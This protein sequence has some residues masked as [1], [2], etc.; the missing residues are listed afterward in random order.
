MIEKIKILIQEIEGMLCLGH[1]PKAET[2]Q[3]IELLLKEIE[4]LRIR[5]KN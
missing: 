3:A 1:Y 4:Y 5:L 2:E